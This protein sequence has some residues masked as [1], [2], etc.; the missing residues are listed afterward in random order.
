M[1][2]QPEPLLA[3]FRTSS[4]CYAFD[5]NTGVIASLP[6]PLFD[7]LKELSPFSDEPPFP[8]GGTRLDPPIETGGGARL[9]EVSETS[10]LFRPVRIRSR[11]T[12]PKLVRE[13][14]HKIVGR[15]TKLTLSV[16]ERCNLRC[17]YCV[18]S[19]GYPGRRTHG[20]DDMSWETAKA[21]LDYFLQSMADAEWPKFVTF[22]GGEPWLNARL[23]QASIAYVS[24]KAPYVQFHTTTNG[25]LLTDDLA[26][27]L[28]AHDVKI[29]VSLDGPRE[30]HD[31]NRVAADGT[32]SFER[33]WANLTRL[34]ERHGDYYQA[35]VSFEATIAD[36]SD[37]ERVVDFFLSYPSVF[38]AGRVKLA[39]MA[40]GHR[41]YDRRERGER[42]GLGRLEQRFLSKL[43]TGEAG[44]SETVLLR[45]LFEPP[46]L[47]IHRRHIDFDRT[48]AVLPS[49]TGAVIWSDTAPR[50][51]LTPELS[52]SWTP[53]SSRP[54]QFPNW[55]SWDLA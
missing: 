42:T 24:A 30:V 14:V 53:S 8:P 45:T 49:I 22:Y 21:A 43:T 27:Y 41:A 34:R 55:R 52:T 48:I 37:A 26:D 1:C 33:I 7:A 36:P 47:T 19:G 25:T 20:L 29:R 6:E 44:A 51:R 28:A 38:A 35:S 3:K 54:R 11:L 23:I 10:G 12:S 2:D 39:R 31:R 18:Y 15:F 9:R 5:A 16:T 17:R 13:H 46:Y 4:A 32:G 40:P 50:S